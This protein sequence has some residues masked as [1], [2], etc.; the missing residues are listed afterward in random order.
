MKGLKEYKTLLRLIGQ[1]KKKLIFAS[2]LIFLSGVAEIF[3]GY[4]NG[5]AVEAITKLQIKNALLFLGIY[6]L[7]EWKKEVK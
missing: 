6:F 1:D 5:A 4:L 3:T 2:V 7:I